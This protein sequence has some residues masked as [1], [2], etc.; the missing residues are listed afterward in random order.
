LPWF[1]GVAAFVLVAGGIFFFSAR[2]ARALTEKDTAVLSEFV[3]TTGDPVFDGTLK[4]A[5]AVQLDQ[6]PY[7]NL[8]PDSKV[9][10][11]LKYMGRKPDERITRDL[12]KEISLRENAKA[13]IAGSI[14]PLGTHYVV[15]LEAINSQTGDSLARQQA[16]AGSKEEVLKSLDKAASGL[17]QKLGESLASVQQFATPLDEATTSSLDA[18][19]EFS[20]GN[21]LHNRSEDDKALEHLKK[22]TDLDAN[23][24]LG[25]ATLGIVN[26]NR[27]SRK[28]AD[29]Q[30][31]KAYDLRERASERERLYITGHYYGKVAGDIEKE[32]DLYHQWLQTYPRD[33]RAWANLALELEQ[34][35]Q[36]D[37]CIE[38]A[39]QDLAV[40]PGDT[41]A[42][43]HQM[44][45]YLSSNRW[46]EARAVADQAI[47]QKKDAVSIHTDLF[48]L[49]V[50]K[51]DDA[52]IN[53]QVAWAS[54]KP[55][56]AGM[57][58]RLSFYQDGLGRVKVAR[59]TGQQ[60]LALANKYGFS[61]ARETYTASMAVRDAFHEFPERARQAASEALRLTDERIV[62]A[63]AALALAQSGDTAQ[64]E[65]VISDLDKAYPADTMLKY[66][67]SPVVRAVAMIRRNQA[68][69]A[70]ALLEPLRQYDLAL[71]VGV[72]NIA[73]GLMYVRGSAYLQM[74]D[75]VKAA[76]EFQ[77]ILDHNGV[78]AASFFLPLAQLNLARAYALQGDS[79]RAKTAYQDFFATWKDADPDVPVLIA[80]KSEY[81]KLK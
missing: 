2:H 10:E 22:A 62:R 15:T 80:A 77:K 55:A 9:Q 46:D 6:S 8:L 70:V 47:S 52:E 53:R 18:L 30:I 4:Q 17:R 61:E 74:K 59:Q 79:A 69:Q 41:Y 7:L 44:A 13:I 28:A 21:E 3:N 78:S 51:R 29:E 24:A 76:S 26:A 42:Y 35:G 34:L 58:L 36:F 64:A 56:E 66:G 54:G 72:G 60:G 40:L 71:A 23:F 20:I 67:F 19:K 50:A 5:L 31:Q 33:T 1:A 43:Q 27:G 81:A 14:A 73:Y 11:A 38:A 65:K 45:C 32:V 75:G 25:W 39:T 63:N 48:F 37:K 16:E 49:A 12:A 57:A 68:S